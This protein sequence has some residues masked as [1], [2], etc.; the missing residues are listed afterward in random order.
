VV[1]LEL[2]GGPPLGLLPATT[3]ECGETVL[4]PGDTLVLHTDGLTEAM[5]PSQALFG[6]TRL[7]ETLAS[8]NGEGLPA[9]RAALLGAL[10]AHRREAPLDDDLSLLLLRRRAEDA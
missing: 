2:R 10:D 1:Q 5:D 3:F 8:C 4:E 7:Q 9:M 6:E